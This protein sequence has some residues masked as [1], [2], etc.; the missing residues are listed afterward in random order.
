[1]YPGDAPAGKRRVSNSH[2]GKSLHLSRID[3]LPGEL[4]RK[5]QSGCSLDGLLFL[6]LFLYFFLVL[7]LRSFA[8]AK[9]PSLRD[10]AGTVM[11]RGP[12]REN[13]Y[14]TVMYSGPFVF[15]G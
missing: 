11:P 15:S 1:M 4:E 6:F 10:V 9:V 3:F 12:T 8:T 13:G 7:E 2:L 14:G 5:A